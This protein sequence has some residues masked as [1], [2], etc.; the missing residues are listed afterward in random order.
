[1]DMERAT[2]K[3]ELA[4]KQL[5]RRISLPEPQEANGMVKNRHGASHVY[6]LPCS[7]SRHPPSIP[8]CGDSLNHHPPPRSASGILPDHLRH[9]RITLAPSPALLPDFTIP[10]GSILLWLSLLV[11]SCGSATGVQISRLSFYLPMKGGESVIP[12][13]G[14]GFSF[15]GCCLSVCLPSFR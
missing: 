13:P 8:A 14:T 12:Q 4:S 2:Q 6:C 9:A 1:M 3:G 10:F 11:N 7:I 15:F 5:L